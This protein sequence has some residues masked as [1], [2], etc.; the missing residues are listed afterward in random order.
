MSVLIA[1]STVSTT[2]TCVWT[3]LTHDLKERTIQLMAQ[4][5]FNQIADQSGWFTKESDHVHSPQQPKNP[6]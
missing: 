3:S 5:A 1:P 4:L 6:A 2:P